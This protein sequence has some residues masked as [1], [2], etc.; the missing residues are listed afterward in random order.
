MNSITNDF[1]SVYPPESYTVTLDGRVVG[2]VEDSI[3]DDL[4]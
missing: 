1:N 3:I 4:V 2:Y